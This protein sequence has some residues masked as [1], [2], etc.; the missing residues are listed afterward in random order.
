[1][2]YYSYLNG[3]SLPGF[4][5]FKPEDNEDEAVIIMS[6]LTRRPDRNLSA[7]SSVLGRFFFH[8]YGRNRF[9]KEIT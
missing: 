9:S 1:M 2:V 8:A 5:L 3:L 4:G 6:C 7:I